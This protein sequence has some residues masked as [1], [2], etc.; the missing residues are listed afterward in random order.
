[1]IMLTAIDTIKASTVM[2]ERSSSRKGETGS[3]AGELALIA[4]VLL[5]ATTLVIFAALR[6]YLVN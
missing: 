3:Q 6:L 1:M 2:P 5:A 4:G